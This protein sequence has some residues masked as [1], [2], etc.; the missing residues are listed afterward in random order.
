MPFVKDFCLYDDPFSFR[1]VGCKLFAIS[2]Q[3]FVLLRFYVSHLVRVDK[4]RH[5]G[6]VVPGI[7]RA[8][9][10]CNSRL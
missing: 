1:V 9:P 10:G 5:P 4:K 6:S 3:F 2:L 8:I 7:A